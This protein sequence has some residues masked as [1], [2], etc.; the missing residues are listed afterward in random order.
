MKI[1][2]YPTKYSRNICLGFGNAGVNSVRHKLSFFLLPNKIVQ[3]QCDHLLQQ[4]LQ[5]YIK[6]VIIK[7]LYYDAW[8]T[9]YQGIWMLPSPFS[10]FCAGICHKSWVVYTGSE[11]YTGAALVL[12]VLNH[13]V[14]V[15][16]HCL[17][18]L[19]CI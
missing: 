7:K 10:A 8:P 4:N 18:R 16:E 14:L 15:K 2:E 3:K 11:L 17:L 13:Q 9:K 19:Y 12:V 6:L 5:D 1:S